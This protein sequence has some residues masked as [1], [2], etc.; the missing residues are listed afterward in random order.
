MYITSHFYFEAIEF[1][2]E[3]GPDGPS[4]ASEI[5]IMGD[6][7]GGGLAYSACIYWRDRYRKL[8]HEIYELKELL[9]K[10]SDSQDLKEISE[11]I[12]EKE[13]FIPKVKRVM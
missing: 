13:A 8:I 6:S 2:W 9:Q 3:N 4:V 11:R 1:L 12:A 5:I 7:A 10:K